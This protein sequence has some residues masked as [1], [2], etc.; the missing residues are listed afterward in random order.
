MTKLVYILN[1]PNLNLLG[2]REPEI[3]GYETMADV[4]ALCADEA[5]RH[6]LQIRFLQSNAEHQLIDWVHEARDEAAAIVINP[7]AYTH[8]SVALLDALNAFGGVV[9]EV[10]IS[11]IHKRE[12]FRHLSYVSKRADGVICGCGTQGYALAIAH[13]AK[14]LG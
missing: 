13:V 3:Y 2:R 12:E 6:G 1:G 5:G 10:H 11:N 8:T 9:I 7:A 4:E 14:R